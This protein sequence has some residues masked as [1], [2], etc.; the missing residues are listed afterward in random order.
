MFA[1]FPVIGWLGTSFVVYL[2][3]YLSGKAFIETLR[4]KS[5]A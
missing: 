4:A 5:G 2:Q 1:V 3:F